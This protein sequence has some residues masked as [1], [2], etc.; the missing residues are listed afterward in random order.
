MGNYKHSIMKLIYN[1]LA[2]TVNY[3]N[4]T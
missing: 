4:F 1:N 3:C 2:S